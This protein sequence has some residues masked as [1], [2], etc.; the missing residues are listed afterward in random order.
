MAL[1]NGEH[2]IRKVTRVWKVSDYIKK[3]FMKMTYK[4]MATVRTTAITGRK[5][6]G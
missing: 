1:L 3:T 2:E 6:N 5:M 4:N